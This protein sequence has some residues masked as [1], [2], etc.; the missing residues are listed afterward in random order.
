MTLESRLPRAETDVDEDG[1]QVIVKA[2]VVHEIK[3]GNARQRARQGMKYSMTS[4]RFS[5]DG[6]LLVTCSTDKSV[7]IFDTITGKEVAMFE[8]ED[9]CRSACFCPERHI[10]PEL[11][12]LP[13]TLEKYLKAHAD[14]GEF[15]QLSEQ[16]QKLDQDAITL[17]TA[18]DDRVARVWRREDE[19]KVEREFKHRLPIW[20][21]DF[22]PNGE[23]LATV[24]K[25]QEV[26]IHDMVGDEDSKKLQHA[27]QVFMAVFSPNSL[28]I[29]TASGW[30]QGHAL[31]WDI[32]LGEIFFTMQHHDWVLSV[33]W[34]P[35]GKR[36]LTACR[37]KGVRIWEVEER[38]D[39]EGIRID[40]PTMCMLFEQSNWPCSAEFSPDGK[41]I[42]V[43]CDD[44]T[45]RVIELEEGWELMCFQ[46]D[47]SITRITFAPDSRR[48]CTTS[49]DGVARVYD[50]LHLLEK[51][52]FDEDTP[53]PPTMKRATIS[54]GCKLYDPALDP[55]EAAAAEKAAREAKEAEEARRAMF[56]ADA[57]D[58][59]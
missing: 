43:A 17:C 36:V 45:A 28:Q 32:D 22:S 14:E 48:I 7:R 35:G 27:D 30:E 12:N 33:H 46:E 39:E 44:G 54:E 13:V 19:N 51:P 53:P 18:C 21:V 24:S 38:E 23:K 34:S 56:L 41:L 5:W 57:S 9:W 58:S 15:D 26:V 8:H 47:V 11:D 31:V 52:V 42:C 29:C 6:S 55:A 4:A 16:W 50:G 2:G 59:D 1:E 20:F 25:N 10:D 40:D 3:H 37:D 49:S